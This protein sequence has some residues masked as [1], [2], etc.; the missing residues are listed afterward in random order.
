M[1]GLCYNQF[2]KTMAISLCKP[3][4]VAAPGGFYFMQ[5]ILFIE[6]FRNFV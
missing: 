4:D 3:F 2:V 5:K 1:Q 6:F